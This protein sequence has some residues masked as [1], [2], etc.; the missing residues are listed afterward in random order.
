MA[1]H[2]ASPAAERA[3]L[4]PRPRDLFR[5]AIH[6]GTGTG[7]TALASLISYPVITRLFSSVDYGLM[8]LISTTV[9]ALV[10]VSKFG[11]QNAAIRF[12]PEYSGEVEQRRLRSTLTL[13]PAATGFVIAA[14]LW[15]VAWLVPSEWLSV[16]SRILLRL[17]SPIIVFDGMKSVLLNFLRAAKQ[18]AKY[19]ALLTIDRYGQLGVSLAVVILVRHDLFG[20]Y[21]GWLSW[22]IVLN[23]YL[24]GQA[25]H[26]NQIRLSAFSIP[27]LGPALRFGAPLLFFELGNLVLTYSDR[28]MV[29]HYLGMAETGMYAAAY[30]FTLAIQALLVVPLSSLIFPWASEIWTHGSREE[31]S[32]FA[33]NML[34]CYLLISVPIMFGGTLLARPLMAVMASEKYIAAGSLLPPLI[35]A[36]IL[37]GVYQIVALGLYLKK[38]TSVLAGQIIFATVLNM[39]VNVWLIPHAG[40]KGAAW[41]TFFAYALLAGLGM[42]ASLPLLPMRFNSRSMMASVLAGAFMCAAV[43]MFAVNTNHGRLI[44]AILCGA[45]IYSALVLA[46]DA[47]VRSFMFGLLARTEGV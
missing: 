27:L 30:N 36:Q 18:S 19:T 22:D 10:S 32:R 16:N 35:A 3:G 33:G 12:F 17:A 25:V 38:R 11:L 37:F 9:N 5:Q 6:Y 21:L 43:R 24:I 7:L 40:L 45:V 39:G 42:R 15:I 8:A 44:P 20:F 14:I 1:T 34:T 23:G 28:Y 41:S 46:F 13:T 31:T 29:A 4:T 26:L 47:G 2:A